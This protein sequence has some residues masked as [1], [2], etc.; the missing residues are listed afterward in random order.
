LPTIVSIPVEEDNYTIVEAGPDAVGRGV[1]CVCKPDNSEMTL[2]NFNKVVR[3]L[4]LMLEI[5]DGIDIT[6]RHL[7][8]E[9]IRQS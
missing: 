4:T 8:A 7:R 1:I 5:D 3:V 2:E 9:Q 6:L